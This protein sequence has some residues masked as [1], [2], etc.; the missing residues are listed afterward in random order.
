VLLFL[1]ND[2]FQTIKSDTKSV[3]PEPV[4]LMVSLFL[5]LF[6]KA[7]ENKKEDITMAIERVITFR[8]FLS[9]WFHFKYE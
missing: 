7:L 2:P 3:F 4:T 9:M 8:L 6:W 1:E 5:F